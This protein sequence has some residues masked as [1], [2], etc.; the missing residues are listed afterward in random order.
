MKRQE[1][2][3]GTTLSVSRDEGDDGIATETLPSVTLPGVAGVEEGGAV[4]AV[5]PSCRVLA[6]SPYDVRGPVAVEMFGLGPPIAPKEEI[7]P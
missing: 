1:L 3:S 4:R 2:S 5:S 6:P 7:A